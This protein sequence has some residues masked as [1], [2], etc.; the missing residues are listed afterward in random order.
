VYIYSGVRVDDIL[1]FIRERGRVRPAEVA[2][3][4]GITPTRASNVLSYLA[5]A[6]DIVRIRHGHYTI[7]PEQVRRELQRRLDRLVDA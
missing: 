7:E 4:F 1:A 5:A 2:D 3:H 6:G